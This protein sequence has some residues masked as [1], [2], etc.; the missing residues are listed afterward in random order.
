[1]NKTQAMDMIKATLTQSFDRDRFR[2]FVL[3]LVNRMDESKAFSRNKQYVKDAFKPHVQKFERLGT[4]TSPDGE[5]VDILIVHLT[6]ASKLERARTA[7][8]NFVADHL[9]GCIGVGS[10]RC[11]G[12]KV[13]WCQVHWGALV[14]GLNI[15]HLS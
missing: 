15:Q 9:R 6:D 11:I 2:P 8:R 14:S 7:I 5:T 4:Y 10:Q 3:N 13:H 1:M 12:V